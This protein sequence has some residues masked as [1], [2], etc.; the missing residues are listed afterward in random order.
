M[1]G[2]HHRGKAVYFVET[3][4]KETIKK[5]QVPVSP[6][7]AHPQCVG[8]AYWVLLPTGG[9]IGWDPSL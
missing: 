7:K 3:E 1:T 6:S 2:T 9:I 4:I 5:G 8:P